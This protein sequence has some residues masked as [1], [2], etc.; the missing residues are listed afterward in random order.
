MK[1]DHATRLN[2][3]RLSRLFGTASAF[4]L[5][6]IVCAQ[7]QGA[8][9]PAVEEVLVTGSLIRGAEAVGVPVTAL[10][11]EEFKQTGAL[12]VS[13]LLRSVPAVQ[14]E[15]STSIANAGGQINR[16]IG[17]DVHTMN[18]S[19]FPRTLMLINSM[20]FSPAGHGT[21]RFDPSIVP[22]L[23]VERVDVLADGASATYG[24]DAIAGVVN[25]IMKRRYD[26]AMTQLRYG[27][28]TDG[29][30]GRALASQ[31]FGR[32]WD[33]GDVTLTYE[34]YDEKG[35]PGAE[36]ANQ[37]SFN[38]EP[39]GLDDRRLV[40]YNV[41]PVYSIGSPNG[42]ALVSGCTNCFS[43][44]RGIGWNYGDTAAH[45][46][47]VTPGGTPTTSWT[48][49]SANAG[50]RQNEID[51][52]FFADVL[53][54]QQRNAATMTFDQRI[55][56][57]VEL[58][59]D[60]FYQNRR[61]QQRYPVLANPVRNSS[62]L[63]ALTVPTT[64]PYYPTGAP[65]GIRVSYN[66]SQELQPA[67]SAN[68]VSGR[69][70][71]GANLEL[72]HE[73][74]GRVFYAYNEEKNVALVYNIANNNNVNA[75]LGNTAASVAPNGSIPGQAAFTKPANVPFLNVFCD[76]FAFTCN[77]PITLAYIAGFRD[78]HQHYNLTEWGA[79]FDGPLFAV[80]G[81]MVK[82]AIGANKYNHN[83]NF[84]VTQNFGPTY[85]TALITKDPDIGK[86]DVWAVYSQLS[87]PLIG[88][89]NAL[90][91]LHSADIELSWRHDHYETYG[92]TDNPKI[93]VNLR[94]IEGL[95][96]RGSWGTSFR[97]PAF[98]DASSVSGGQVQ[99]LNAAAGAS[100]TIPVCNTGETSPP[101]GS[102]A[103]ALVRLLSPAN[104]TCAGFSAATGSLFPGGIT[105]RG[106]AGLGSLARGG[107]SLTPEKA[108]NYSL[109]FQYQPTAGFLTG[110]DV[111]LTYFNLKV[112]HLLQAIDATTA[113]LRDPSLAFTLILPSD[114]NFTSLVAAY[115]RH[116]RAEVITESNVRFIVD[117]AVRNTGFVKT[118]GFDFSLGYDYDTGATGTVNAGIDGTYF[119]HRKTQSVAGT[120]PVEAYSGDSFACLFCSPPIPPRLRYRIH[121]GWT[122]TD[123]AWNAALFMNYTSHYFHNQATPP[124]PTPNYSNIVPA[125]VTLDASVGYNTGKDWANTYLQDID[126]RLVVNDL[127]NKFP[128]FMYK[129]STGGSNPAAFDISQN[130]I[131]RTVTLVLTKT[132]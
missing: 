128:P 121:L 36:R 118:D 100:N 52:Y 57:M 15:A 106:G 98:S 32:R 40:S 104:P 55:H 10:G 73:W 7:A 30:G 1:F 89:M 75:A 49:I 9:A 27:Q 125:Y 19:S 64:N 54:Y 35:V 33:S 65:A 78:Y 90:P 17:I 126:I 63:R 86:Q 26:G 22:A 60:A 59:A 85:S 72:P 34:W 39:W 6:T 127:M 111:E 103:E 114:P 92:S 112:D 96:L 31:L 61:V 18:S 41:P 47:P 77:S 42:G 8:A 131:G 94:P 84:V 70:S 20:R 124:N 80:P 43:L 48:T 74:S 109:G 14:V 119:L 132:W 101:A 24:S 79:T 110:L 13:D 129:I 51:P 23:A 68:E 53:A 88:E 105:L 46:N 130:P 83:Y 50:A 25:V 62:N 12:T 76:P 99:P 66:I 93:G 58:F 82:A 120:T 29:E 107:L 37:F 3:A 81:G 45:T 56:P 11:T 115:V 102:G 5:A 122:S 2:V 113:T 28:A 91:F 38:Y 117:A 123:S 16:S 87:V 71:V 97:A 44:P 67:L 4:T 108:K 116:P 69:W 95:T 21:D